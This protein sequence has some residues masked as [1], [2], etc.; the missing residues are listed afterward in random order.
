MGTSVSLFSFFKVPLLFILWLPKHSADPDQLKAPRLIRAANGGSLTVSCWYDSQ[1]RDNSKYWC[2]GAV[3]EFCK[4]VVKTPKQR[5]HNRWSIADDKEAG[6]FIVTMT[7]VRQSDGDKYWCVVAR[8]GRNIVA[9]VKLIVSNKVIAPT[10]T[11]PENSSE[12]N[13]QDKTRWWEP[14]RWIIFSS[15]LFSLVSAHGAVW[16]IKAA[17]KT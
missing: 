5:N 16:R 1:F 4:I 9:G 11:M 2:R 15:M 14:L 3:Y 8:P 17:H 6:A 7:S 12:S 13:E 10:S